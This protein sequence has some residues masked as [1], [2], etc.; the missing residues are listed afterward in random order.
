MQ[1]DKS[2]KDSK[3]YVQPIPTFKNQKDESL[4]ESSISKE[5]LDSFVGYEMD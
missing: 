2:F 3:Y 4:S 5:D 1:K